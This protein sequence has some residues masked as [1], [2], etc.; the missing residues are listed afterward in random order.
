MNISRIIKIITL[1]SIIFNADSEKLTYFALTGILDF[2]A[3]FVGVIHE[4]EEKIKKLI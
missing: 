4:N 3:I 1:I 2:G